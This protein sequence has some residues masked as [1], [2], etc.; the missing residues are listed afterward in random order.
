MQMW[1]VHQIL[2]PGVQHGQKTDLG[3]QV[4]TVGGDLQERLG[5]RPKQQAVNH[6]RIVQRQRTELGR[7]REHDMEVRHVD[8]LGRAGFEPAC[9]GGCLALWAVAVAARIV[10]EAAMATGVARFFVSAQRGGAAGGE[11][12]DRTALFAA[13]YMGVSMQE[14]GSRRAKHVANLGLGAVY[15]VSIVASA[16]KGLVTDMIRSVDTAV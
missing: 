2:A 1:V 5:R 6:A 9:A 12:L 10:R 15:A 4:L 16:S 13:D 8:Q 14:F 7:Q 11:V 3:P